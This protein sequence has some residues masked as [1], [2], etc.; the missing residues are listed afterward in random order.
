MNF[1]VHDLPRDTVKMLDSGSM[2]TSLSECR[3]KE[4][5]GPSYL[6]TRQEFIVCSLAGVVSG[7]ADGAAVF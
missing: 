4:L 6:L 1:M 2:V 3:G 5:F 7:W